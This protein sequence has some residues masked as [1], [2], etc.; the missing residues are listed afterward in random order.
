MAKARRR[1]PTFNSRNKHGAQGLKS[2]VD[3]TTMLSPTNGGFHQRRPTI[4]I[5]DHGDTTA[6]INRTSPNTTLQFLSEPMRMHL[7][8]VYDDLRGRSSS[9]SKAKFARFLERTQGET[10][11]ELEGDRYKFEEFLEVW[12]Y[13]FHWDAQRRVFGVKDLSRPISNYF[14]SSSHNTYLLGNQLSSEAS[15]EAYRR[16]SFDEVSFT[17][18]CHRNTLLT[19]LANI[20][21]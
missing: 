1:M 3:V 17:C 20:R 16:V 13:H 5:T 11:F 15:A 14:I 21:C 2:I 8:R 7:R 18:T 10:G 6:V 9:L 4:R 19:R 12:S